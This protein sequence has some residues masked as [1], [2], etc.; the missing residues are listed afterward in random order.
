MIN[1]QQ[2]MKIWIIKQ[3]SQ[4][5]QSHKKTQTLLKELNPILKK[6]FAHVQ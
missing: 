6:N 4:A 2:K 3:S 5:L 1:V